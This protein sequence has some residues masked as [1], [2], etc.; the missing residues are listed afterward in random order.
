MMSEQE[1][2]QLLIDTQA[3]LEGHFLLTSGLHSPMYLS[4]IHI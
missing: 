3:I 1:V 2:K 4:L